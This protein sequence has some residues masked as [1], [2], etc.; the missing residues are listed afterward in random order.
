[1]IEKIIKKKKTECPCKNIKCERHGNCIECIKHHKE[2]GSKTA[3]G[4]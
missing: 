4:K 1:M 3:C 2:I